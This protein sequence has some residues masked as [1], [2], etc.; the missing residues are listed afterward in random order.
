MLI[1]EDEDILRTAYVTIFTQEKFKVH[2][3]KNGKVALDELP[4]AKPDIIILDILMPVMNGIEFL[5]AASLAKKYPNTKVLVLSNLSDSDT[6]KLITELGASQHL[7]K[8]SLS[9][10]QLVT[11]VRTL[12]NST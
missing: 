11:S 9:P 7:V 5:Q 8:S 10:R 2:S 12:L 6:V 3:A 4:K 1:V